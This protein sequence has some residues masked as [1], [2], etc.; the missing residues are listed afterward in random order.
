MVRRS[1]TLLPIISVTAPVSDLPCFVSCFGLRAG[2]PKPKILQAERVTA[3]IKES[4]AGSLLCG[5]AESDE[6]DLTITKEK[7]ADRIGQASA[8]QDERCAINA[9]CQGGGDPHK[10]Q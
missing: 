9:A 4:L 7:I 6:A 8:R 5:A 3:L 1:S 2:P 10:E